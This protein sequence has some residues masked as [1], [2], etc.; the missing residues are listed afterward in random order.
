MN[1][2]Q[3]IKL[4][5]KYTKL[6]YSMTFCKQEYLV[7]EFRKKFP[8]NRFSHQDV[9][10]IVEYFVQNGM[11]DLIMANW[12][13]AESAIAE[14]KAEKEREK[15]KLQKMSALGREAAIV[16]VRTGMIDRKLKWAIEHGPK[17]MAVFALFNKWQMK[18]YISYV[19]VSEDVKVMFENIDTIIAIQKSSVP[20]AKLQMAD[21]FMKWEKE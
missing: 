6:G 20:L 18:F 12:T 5:K 13:E 2:S 15:L 7:E 17:R 3:I 10:R 16:L 19:N 11:A 14:E 1:T 9:P 4:I 8:G 21:R